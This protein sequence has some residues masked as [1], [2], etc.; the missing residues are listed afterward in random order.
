MMTFEMSLRFL[1]LRIQ[2]LG[3]LLGEGPKL[4]EI[5]L[6]GCISYLKGL[7]ELKVST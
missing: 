6:L 4:S 5:L 7:I 1:G 3:P 2:A